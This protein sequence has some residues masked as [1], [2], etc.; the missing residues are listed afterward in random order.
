LHTGNK[1]LLILAAVFIVLAIV[2]RAVLPATVLRIGIGTRF[3]PPG[4]VAF[5]VFWGAGLVTAMIVILKIN[6]RG[7]G[8]E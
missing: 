1:L 4:Q 7:Q 6:V 5:W 3:Y 8:T 2:L